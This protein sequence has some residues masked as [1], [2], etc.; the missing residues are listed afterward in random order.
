MSER[1]EC[2]EKHERGRRCGDCPHDDRLVDHLGGN[3]ALR[4]EL[5][6]R[7]TSLRA[8]VAMKRQA[9]EQG[10]ADGESS[11]SAD[12][13]VALTDAKLLPEDAEVTPSVVVAMV[14]R[15]VEEEREACAK[16][17]DDDVQA[18][19][20]IMRGTA[21]SGSRKHYER[22]AGSLRALA[23]AIRRRGEG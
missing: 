8:R 7:L 4:E 2:C 18:C 3:P 5:L 16:M 22:M 23:A 14:R 19:E 13:W 10:Y 15:A 12:Y 20:E 6:G 17:V 1:E 21:F 9:Y 11:V